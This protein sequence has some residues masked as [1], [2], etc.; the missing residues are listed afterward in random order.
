MYSTGY[1]TVLGIGVKIRISVRLEDHA[2]TA[3]VASGSLLLWAFEVLQWIYSLERRETLTGIPD[4]R[5][6]DS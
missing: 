5:T 1:R 6:M 4:V 3:R 2:T